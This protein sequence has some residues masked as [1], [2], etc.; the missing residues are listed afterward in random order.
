[1][2]EL[3]VNEL[4][5]V[6][7]GFIITAT[8]ALI[9]SAVIAGV[10]LTNSLINLYTAEKTGTAPTQPSS[11]EISQISGDVNTIATVISDIHK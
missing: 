10:Y 1:M 11:S 8:V 5:A 6:Q 2:R 9:T 4:D 3:Q 7:G